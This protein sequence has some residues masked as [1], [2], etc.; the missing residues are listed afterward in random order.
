[1]VLYRRYWASLAP[2]LVTAL[3]IGLVSCAFLT[4]GT[5][6]ARVAYESNTPSIQ[7]AG[8][9]SS[10]ENPPES[11]VPPN[12]FAL[13]ETIKRDFEW[14][15]L[16]E[17]TA[18]IIMPTPKIYDKSLATISLL[19]MNSTA[20]EIIVQDQDPSLVKQLDFSKAE[21]VQLLKVDTSIFLEELQLYIKI[22]NVNNPETSYLSLRNGTNLDAPYLGEDIF[23]TTVVFKET[24]WNSIHFS[25]PLFLSAGNY[26]VYLSSKWDKSQSGWCRSAD[27]VNNWET[28]INDQGTW[29]SVDWDLYVK[30]MVRDAVDLGKFPVYVNKTKVTPTEHGCGFADLS[31]PITGDTV[32]FQVNC[33]TSSNVEANVAYVVPVSVIFYHQINATFFRSTIPEIAITLEKTMTAWKLIP[34]VAPLAA[35]YHDY[36]VLINGFH[37]DQTNILVLNG[38]EGC[39]YFRINASTIIT[40][41]GFDL[42]LFQGPNYVLRVNYPIKTE[43]GSTI[44]IVVDVGAWGALIMEITEGNESLYRSTQEGTGQ[45]TFEWQ[46]PTSIAAEVVSFKIFFYGEGKAGYYEGIIS[47]QPPNFFISAWPYFIAIGICAS[48]GRLMYVKQSIVRAK[49]SIVGFMILHDKG[50]SVA[51]VFSPQLKRMDPEEIADVVGR[52]ISLMRNVK[53]GDVHVQKIDGVYMTIA[54]GNCFWVILF[55][56]S[57]PAKLRNSITALLQRIEKTQGPALSTWNGQ[58]LPIPLELL[59]EET[60]GAK[61]MDDSLPMSR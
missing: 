40:Y 23:S 58:K 14:T 30:L 37:E 61:I 6:K 50:L 59:L 28:W 13:F 36:K 35:P 45:L 60:L 27:G 55:T 43:P 9:P 22:Q 34:R 42:V 44:K 1:M 18:S 38:T 5:R 15:P 20:H 4:N 49:R 8:I 46:V 26:C 29:T 25:A 32:D 53:Q 19:A 16:N 51:E 48:L 12:N 10:S 17:N 3:C 57:N 33:P 2:I 47:I 54:R 11:R 24:A 56:R 39:A 31:Q 52:S 41:S 7:P 21:Q